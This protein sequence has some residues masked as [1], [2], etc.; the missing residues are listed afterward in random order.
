LHNA[1]F[2]LNTRLDSCTIPIQ[3][4]PIK[5]RQQTTTSTNAPWPVPSC[6]PD[7]GKRLLH[8]AATIQGSFSTRSKLK[9][10]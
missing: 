10:V 1:Y 5:L 2:F 3:S 7:S 4:L 6:E 9:T 8:C